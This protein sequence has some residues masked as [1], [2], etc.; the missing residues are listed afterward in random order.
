M[1]GGRGRA[2]PNWTGSGTP[3]DDEETHPILRARG[4]TRLN[5]VWERL[6][7]TDGDDETPSEQYRR[8]RMAML[9]AEREAVMDI[10]DHGT[11]DSEVLSEIMETSTS[12]NR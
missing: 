5:H 3:D 1:S 12:R 11:T 2:G 7:R 4:E 10:R 6:G 9:G 8:L